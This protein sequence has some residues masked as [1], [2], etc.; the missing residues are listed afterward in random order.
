MGGVILLRYNKREVLSDYKFFCFNG[1]VELCYVSDNSHS[2]E[3]H[4]QFFDKNFN[5]LPIMRKDYLPYKV[6]PKKP[7]NLDCIIHIAE[8]LSAHIPHVR[9]DFYVV[10]GNLYFGEFTFYTGSGYIPFSD[11]KW[12][13]IIGKWLKL[14]EKRIIN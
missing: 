6:I 8:K 3:Q 9:V 12:D 11:K 2:V 13:V 14:P 1:K 7:D 10:Q 5:P 4:I